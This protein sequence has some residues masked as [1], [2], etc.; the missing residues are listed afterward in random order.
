MYYSWRQ[1]GLQQCHHVLVSTVMGSVVVDRLYYLSILHVHVKRNGA[2][3]PECT[4][5]SLDTNISFYTVSDVPFSR[6]VGVSD[7]V[8]ALYRVL[9]T[10]LRIYIYKTH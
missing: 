6:L 2:C 9:H 7:T 4:P 5:L 10:L 3:H 1:L 8:Q